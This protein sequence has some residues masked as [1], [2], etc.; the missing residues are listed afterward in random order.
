MSDRQPLLLSAF[1][2]NRQIGQTL[3]TPNGRVEVR[4]CTGDNIRLVEYSC[5]YG[6][7]PLNGAWLAFATDITDGTFDGCGIE[8]V[9]PHYDESADSLR[10]VVYYTPCDDGPT[11]GQAPNP[12]TT[13]VA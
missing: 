4:P 11:W 12:W 5:P 10:I 8:A 6:Q 1:M 7:D 3:I 2:G 13:K 9:T